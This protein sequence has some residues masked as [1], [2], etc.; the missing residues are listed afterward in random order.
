MY[1]TSSIPL[2]V[3][4]VIG[5]AGHVDHGK[6]SLVHALTGVDPDNLKD[7][8]SR[9][10]TI[11]PGFGWM[12]LPS[13]RRVS[14]VDVPGHERFIKN[15]VLGASSIDVALIVIAADEGIMPQTI[16][17]CSILQI[18]GV[19][20]AIVVISKRDLVDDEWFEY[21]KE[22]ITE[23][24]ITK[25]VFPDA[26]IVPVST[27]KNIGFEQ[28]KL[29]IDKTVGNKQNH[30]NF[31]YPRIPI[32]RVFNKPGFGTVITGKVLNMEIHTGDQ[33]ELLPSLDP[34]RVRTIQVHGKK[35]DRALP[36]SRIAINLGNT[37]TDNV[38][39]GNILATPGTIRPTI[40]FDGYFNCSE[41]F[42]RYL[43][44]NHKVTVFT[45]TDEVEGTAR[46]FGKND[47][48]KGESGWIQVKT[49]RNI[50]VT[51]GDFYILR[52]SEETIGGGKVLIP[53]AKRHKREN[54]PNLIK[55]LEFLQA[56][57]Y[58]TVIKNHIDEY[59]ITTKEEI[60][61]ECQINYRII[62]NILTN[63]EDDK[64]LLLLSN[65][66]DSYFITQN[67]LQIMIEKIVG[68][69][70]KYHKD[71]ASRPGIPVEECRFSM[72]LRVGPFQALVKYLELH[73]YLQIK[74][75]N[76]CYPNYEPTL[77]KI[78]LGEAKQFVKDLKNYGY[79]PPGNIPITQEI[80][81]FLTLNGEVVKISSDI[82]Y[83]KN[84]AN[85]LINGIKELAYKDNEITISSVRD[86]FGTSRKYTLAILE[87]MD[88]K[89]IT[90]RNGDLRYIR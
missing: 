57:K 24:F 53:N 50:S 64:Y 61:E 20:D 12:D 59:P 60:F 87:Y 84:T 13:G 46:I 72:G 47:I 15:M 4:Y 80:L 3:E 36:G 18:Y 82:F 1:M 48:Q 83:E 2:S 42:P 10:L 56:R 30:M 25:N 77:S 32:D 52:D 41:T 17:H 33:L 5:T 63:M 69:V 16:E 86:K 74:S 45:G 66:N 81:D 76:L 54:H 31:T 55:K 39:K 21:L 65:K 88:S 26:P 29:Q 14:V 67:R 8:K 49:V 6:S 73:N 9:G 27:T 71:N 7:E 40:A 23:Y 38:S 11:E 28:L 79:T 89:N 43:K 90:R 75:A 62:D 58:S 51:H 70:N 78:Q 35:V 19:T 68:I 85:E 34:V 37:N 22:E 44:H